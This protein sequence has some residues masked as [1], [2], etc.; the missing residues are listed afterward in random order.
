MPRK[1]VTAF[2]CM[3][4]TLALALPVPTW[5]AEELP[6]HVL[7]QVDETSG[8][9]TTNHRAIRIFDDGKVESQEG[10]KWVKIA[11]L[12]EAMATRLKKVTDVMTAKSKLYTK[13]SGLADGPISTYLVKN[14]EGAVVL[15]GK[16]GPQDSILLQG[17]ASSI[18]EVLDGFKTL[19]TI[20]Y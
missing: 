8:F 1:S 13:D 18:I 16:K 7:A 20:S 9:R 19:S 4:F 11:Q 17:G 10:E 2:L 14:K 15:I 6:P 3:L 12:S 5:A